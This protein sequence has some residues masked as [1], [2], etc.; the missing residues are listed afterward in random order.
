[1]KTIKREEEQDDR[2]KNTPSTKQRLQQG[3]THQT[4]HLQ[5][6]ANRSNT[7]ETTTGTTTKIT[8]TTTELLWKYNAI[9]R[10]ETQPILALYSLYAQRNS[11]RN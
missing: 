9:T 7:N 1:M 6:T 3:K 2:R 10:K 4:T 5:P 8:E 11:P